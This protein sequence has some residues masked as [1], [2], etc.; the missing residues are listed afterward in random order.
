[1]VVYSISS[2]I[3][4]SDKIKRTQNSFPFLESFA[5]KY[6]QKVFEDK[7]TPLF[8]KTNKYNNF[9]VRYKHKNNKK[10]IRKTEKSVKE[11]RNQNS[12][13]KITKIKKK[14][15]VTGS[16]TKVLNKLTKSNFEKQSDELLQILINSKEKFSVVLI[17]ELVLEKI[18]YDKGF[19]D[20]YVD[21]CKKLWENNEWIE[22]YLVSEKNSGFDNFKCAFMTLCR[23]NFNNR[24]IFIE[25][26]KKL[27]NFSSGVYKLKRK[28][29]GT[30]E[31]LGH[32]Y[33]N[34]LI[35][36][37][38]IHYI[39][40]SLFHT[41]N[42]HMNGC[43][44]EEEVEAI[45]LLWDIVESKIDKKV[46]GEY[47]EMLRKEKGKQWGSRTNFMVID[48]LNSID[49]K[50]IVIE[51]KNAKI[52]IPKEEKVENTKKIVN[53]SR[54]FDEENIVKIRGLLHCDTEDIITNILKDLV[55]YGEYSEN[56]LKTVLFLYEN[57]REIDIDLLSQSISKVGE[58]V[59]DIKIDAPKAPKNM[60]FAI[61]TILKKTKQ[62]KL[63]IDL[64]EIDDE[65][66]SVDEVKDEW[67]RIIKEIDSE[68]RDFICLNVSHK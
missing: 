47:E 65:Y 35:N 53:L 51:K 64:S 59:I 40:L 29:F 25:E 58:M 19:Y 68:F 10:S 9:P 26:C 30:V 44:Y 33:K 14:S 5:G 48:M 62:T 6:S 2:L 12:Q 23:D 61:S 13:I 3:E 43:S 46:M 57:I 37:D 21:L 1:M 52:L 8:S 45:K 60:A 17:A 15:G 63:L 16:V 50:D 38:I 4:F 49:S 31:I 39:L 36:E 20:L 32:F 56:H 41:D 42:I 7:K 11:W 24:H 27:D 28:L 34:D 55:E 67:E 54:N 22:N 18:W 66:V